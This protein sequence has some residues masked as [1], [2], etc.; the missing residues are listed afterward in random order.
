MKVTQPNRRVLITGLGAVTALAPNAAGT[1]NKLISGVCGISAIDL[2][3]TSGYRVRIGAQVTNFKPP[4]LCVSSRQLRRLSR[5]DRFGLSATEEAFRDAKIN[6]SAENRE[7]I[8]I[9][10]G[11]GAGGVLLAEKYRRKIFQ[12]QQ[13]KPSML[14]PFATCSTA[15]CIASAYNISGPRSTIAT[16]CSSSATAIGYAA[17]II[18]QGRADLMVTGGSESL[19]ELTF[20][21]FNAMRLLDNNPCKPFDRGRNGLSLGEG[22][23]ILILEESNRALMRKAEVYGELMGYAIT[24]D[25]HHMTSPAPDGRGAASAMQKALERCNLKP[26]Q[27]DYINA[28]GTGTLIND[29]AETNAIKKVFADHAYKIPVSS[30][31][32]MVG[33]CLGAAGALE[34]FAT[35]LTVKHSVIPPTIS[36]ETSDPECDL[37]FVPNKARP[38][39]VTYAMSNSFAFGGNNTTL[40]F[41]KFEEMR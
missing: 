24:G 27:V 15:D 22:A 35:V 5:C 12:G 1:W 14:L 9:C 32:S 34:A 40:V 7:R 3:D 25:A 26:A 2:F 8:G 16:A 38:Q 33:H 21:G 6:L 19:C 13:A 4:L 31:K 39:S 18:R 10:L 36:Y 20:G 37:D 29:A 23:A 17:D 41:R 11:G 30:V 28:H